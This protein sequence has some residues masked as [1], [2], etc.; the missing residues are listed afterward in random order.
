MGSQ[1]NHDAHGFCR[2][3][4]IHTASGYSK[5]VLQYHSMGAFD[6]LGH[7]HRT[8]ALKPIVSCNLKLFVWIIFWSYLV[9]LLTFY[10]PFLVSG[11]MR[12]TDLFYGSSF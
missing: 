7:G 9:D 2:N 1:W 11:V 12:E 5:I 4:L 10:S 6:N 3:L 8:S